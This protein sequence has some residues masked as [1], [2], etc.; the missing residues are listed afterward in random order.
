[1]VSMY[2]LFPVE[3][4]ALATYTLPAEPSLIALGAGH[5][6]C[7]RGAEAWFYPLAGGSALRRQYS[8]PVDVL[9]VAANRAV[10][11]CQ[12]RALLHIV[13]SQFKRDKKYLFTSM[14]KTWDTQPTYKIVDKN[15][16]KIT[17][18]S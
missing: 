16:H 6:C 10:A 9:R 8:G 2:M 14:T 12:G 11:L 1:M 18:N 4:R 17:P 13:S 3:P 7:V 5:V 15:I